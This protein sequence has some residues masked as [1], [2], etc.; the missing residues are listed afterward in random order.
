[1]LNRVVAKFNPR[2]ADGIGSSS[3]SSGAANGNI[4]S[5]QMV[6]L[7]NAAAGK[8]AA[9]QQ[10]QEDAQEFLQFLVDAAHEEVMKLRKELGLDEEQDH[11][12][13]ADEEEEWS[14]VQKGKK[15]RYAVTRGTED[16]GGRSVLSSI[17]RGSMKSQVKAKTPG[18]TPPSITV[19]PFTM[20]HL[21]I[22]S[23]SVRS[24][25]DALDVLTASE[26]IHGYR[27]KGVNEAVEAEKSIKLSKLPQVLVLHLM[28]FSFGVQGSSK[29]HHPVAFG[30]MLK[31]KPSWMSEDCPG[32]KNAEYKLIATVIHHGRNSTGGHYTSHVLQPDGQWLHFNDAH[33]SVVSQHHVLSERTYLLVYQKLT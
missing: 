21:D 20:L 29:L 13:G 30:P 28:R 6:Q 3:S 1:M 24:I 27:V 4:S 31:L 7:K 8:A 11:T 33:V 9:E 25:D 26:T 23:N 14:Q 5:S 16:L 22:S 19:Q 10:E 17:F 32:R 18:T 15:N 12:H 2:R